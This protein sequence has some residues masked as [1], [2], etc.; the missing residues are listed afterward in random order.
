MQDLLKTSSKQSNRPMITK[1]IS[2]GQTG[3]D[4]AGL[5]YAISYNIPHGGMC[6]QGRRYEKGR[7]P[8]KYNLTEHH[9]FNYLP[10]TLENVRNSDATLIF[11]LKDNLTGGCLRTAQFCTS[12]K[13][14]YLHIHPKLDNLTEVLCDF[15]EFHGV[16]IL[17]VAGS[18]ESKENGIYGWTRAILE[19]ITHLTISD[20]NEQELKEQPTI[21]TF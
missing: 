14:P 17:N 19:I 16:T 8:D 21:H 10:R 4:L 9:S 18:R 20:G 7:I 1:I 2:G 5:D 12:Q 3:G 15:I 6:P 13:K 11:T